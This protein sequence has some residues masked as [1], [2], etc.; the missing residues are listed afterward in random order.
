MDEELTVRD[1]MTREYVGVSESDT[2]EDVV[3]L[4][5]EDGTPGVVVLRGSEPVGTVDERAVLSEVVA[6]DLPSDAPVSD[7]M[8]GPDPRVNETDRL[9]EAVS[10]LSTDDR[11][12][13]LVTA[14]ENGEVVGLLSTEDVIAAATSMLA[15]AGIEASEVET[16]VQRTIAGEGR[17]P[18]SDDADYTTQS[19]CE[20]CGSLM[21]S[22]QNVNG[23]VVCGDCRSV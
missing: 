18:V 20:V 5:L 11:K 8:A 21:P 15:N 13:L 19:V 1:V 3:A 17:E 14:E 7:V 9:A 4:M 22:L 10:I 12:H 2:V 6:G 16:D 23:Q